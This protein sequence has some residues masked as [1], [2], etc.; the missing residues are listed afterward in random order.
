MT[1]LCT[2]SIAY[3]YLMTFPGYFKDHILPDKLECLS[4]SFLVDSMTK[5]RGGIAPNIAYTLA[6]LGDRPW[7]MGTVGEDFDD[8]RNWLEE[9]HVDTRYVRVIM[10][11]YTASF[12]ANTDLENAQIASFYTGAMANAAE[13]SLHELAKTPPELVIISPNDPKAMRQLCEESLEMKLPYLYDPSQQIVRMDP[14]DI[15]FGT[16]GCQSLFLNDYEYNLLQRHTGLTPSEILSQGRLVVV[17][18]GEKGV[19]VYAEGKEYAIPIAPVEKIIDPTGV[20]DAFRGG[21][22]RGFQL[23]LDWQTCGQMGSLAAAYCLEQRGTQNHSFTPA[24]FVQRY[25]SIYNDHGK[26][27]ALLA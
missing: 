24:E 12:F 14:E 17:T 2:G 10:G 13:I 3:D 7:L 26:L 27:N 1:I 9:R 16:L 8:Y 20:G 19:V 25:R 6:L 5:Q 4:L 23:K 15:R 22:L 11:K 18:K 21:F